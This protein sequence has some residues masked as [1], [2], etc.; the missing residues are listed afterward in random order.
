MGD[1]EKEQKMKEATVQ[2]DNVLNGPLFIDDTLQI[3]EDENMSKPKQLTWAQRTKSKQ[4]AKYKQMAN[5]FRENEK[6]EI[7]SNHSKDSVRSSKSSISSKSNR[8]VKK[9]PSKMI[10]TKHVK[11]EK[12][13][14]NGWSKV[15]YSKK[16]KIQN[17]NRSKSNVSKSQ[18]Q[19]LQQA[20]EKKKL[21]LMEQRK[22][23]KKIFD[24]IEEKRMNLQKNQNS[25]I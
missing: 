11:Q 16:T 20:E 12:F 21:Q 17:R 23:H 2:M 24:D 9:T 3:A 7:S 4:N 5:N 19:R 15:Y 13:D 14:A 10:K 6:Y 22:K 18:Q 1:D 8:K 25:K